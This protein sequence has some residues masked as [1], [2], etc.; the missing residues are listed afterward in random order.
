M[1]NLS[2]ILRIIDLKYKSK[3]PYLRILYFQDTFSDSLCT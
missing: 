3:Y 2:A 1:F